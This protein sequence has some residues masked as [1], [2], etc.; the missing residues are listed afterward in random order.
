MRM[1]ITVNINTLRELRLAHGLDQEQAAARCNISPGYWNELE[2]GK[3]RGSPKK[4][5]Q[6]ADAFAPFATRLVLT[7]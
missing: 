2:A 6:I 5:W 1:G 3:R 7:K 4:T